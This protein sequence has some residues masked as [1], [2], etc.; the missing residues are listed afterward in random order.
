MKHK[1]SNWNIA[2]EVSP[3]LAASG[4]FGDKSGV[5]RINYNLIRYLSDY[6]HEEKL[7]HQ[8][9][10]YTLNPPL[11]YNISLDLYELIQRDNI[12]LIKLPH[13]TA[14]YL[15]DYKIFDHLIIR[16]II[17]HLNNYVYKPILEKTLFAK[18]LM[19]IN[20]ILKKNHVKIIH[21]S[22]SGFVS[23]GNFKNV[24]HINDLVPIKFPFWQ[25]KMTVDIHK[26]KLRFAETYA[27]GIIC[28]SEST[29]RDLLE[30]LPSIKNDGHLTEVIYLGANNLDSK[31]GIPFS[32]L[33]HVIKGKGYG[34]IESQKYLL[35][36]GTIE[37]RKNINLLVSVFHHL[38]QDPDFS[39]YKFVLVGG[40][41][42][43]KAY[44]SLQ[45]FV[46]EHYPLLK[47]S[48]IIPLDFLSDDYLSA[49]I[50]NARA[51]VYPS[52]YEGFGLP[53][54]ESMLHKTPVIT[55]NVSSLPEAGGDACIYVDP[56]DPA[57]LESSMRQIIT[58]D[59]LYAELVKKGLRHAH[60]FSWKQSA[61]STYHFYQKLL[62]QTHFSHPD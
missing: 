26:R 6:F 3:I 44:D 1:T 21:H 20:R 37:P 61:R 58:D 54:V 29:K 43:G 4:S 16:F 48:P 7:P 47:D 49:L 28:I 23:L 50:E 46:R 19:Q 40:R 45:N 5:Y 15:T 25:R 55:S 53:V 56:L 39:S 10:L 33:N 12:H 35:Y 36:F 14:P 11:I 9:Y 34:S 30:Y 57:A 52:L 24:I 8:I 38:V 32:A 51:V 62:R 42:W 18:Y 60:K 59:A 31:R 41:G 17:K 22:E 2:F 13:L 27:Q